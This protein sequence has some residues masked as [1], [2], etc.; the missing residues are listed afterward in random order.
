MKWI[1]NSSSF[2]FVITRTLNLLV[3]HCDNSNHLFFLAIYPSHCRPPDLNRSTLPCV[4]RYSKSILTQSFTIEFSQPTLT[5]AILNSTYLW[6]SLNTQ[7]TMCMLNLKTNTWFPLE[8]TAF[9]LFYFLSDKPMLFHSL[10]KID[11]SNT[12]TNIEI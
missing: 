9:V 3:Y 7:W 5:L 8:L 12:N 1:N 10:I 6:I 2:T 11:I 4:P